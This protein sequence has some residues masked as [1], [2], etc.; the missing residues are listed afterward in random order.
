MHLVH[1]IQPRLSWSCCCTAKL[2]CLALKHVHWATTGVGDYENA[3]LA[4]RVI[5]ERI[6]NLW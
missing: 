1:K 3:S 4:D 6:I 2:R 5:E